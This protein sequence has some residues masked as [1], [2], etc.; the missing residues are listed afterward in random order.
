MIR[1][2]YSPELYH[3]GIK[4]Q[5]WGVRRFQNEDGTLTPEGKKRYGVETSSFTLTKDNWNSKE[6]KKW[7]KRVGKGFF[8]GSQNEYFIERQV[9]DKGRSVDLY[10]DKKQ[11]KSNNRKDMNPLAR[12]SRLEVGTVGGIRPKDK[13]YVRVRGKN[14]KDAKKLRAAATA[15]G[16]ATL[17]LG[18]FE[19]YKRYKN[20]QFIAAMKGYDFSFGAFKGTAKAIVNA[21]NEAF[22]ARQEDRKSGRINNEEE[23]EQTHDIFESN[24]DPSSKSWDASRKRLSGP[25]NES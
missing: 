5:K 21:A 22:K 6:G 12:M 11:F 9:R 14:T 23:Y 15:F 20:V 24:Y 19:T 16:A 8:N 4:G 17:A 25:T 2:Q 1:I 13:T 7:R 3:H 10:L 18:I